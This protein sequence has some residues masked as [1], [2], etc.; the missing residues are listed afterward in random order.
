MLGAGSGQWL[1]RA[2]C[3]RSR[4]CECRPFPRLHIPDAKPVRLDETLAAPGGHCRRPLFSDVAD[5]RQHLLAEQF[6]RFH[7]LVGM[8]RARGSRTT[9]R[10][11]RRRS[12]RGTASIARRLV[13]P[14]A[15]VDRQHS[16][17]IGRP[18]PLA[19]DVAL[20][21]FQQRGGDP[22][23]GGNTASRGY[24]AS[25]CCAFSPVSAIRMLAR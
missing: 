5:V 4:P 14:A 1:N 16:V 23:F 8:F 3:R 20:V 11:L 17:N 22:V 19:G 24:W 21:E 13:Q 25:A 15:E 9:D 6:E 12:V 18:P 10:R 2:D 7:Q